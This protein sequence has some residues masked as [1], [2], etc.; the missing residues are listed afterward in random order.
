MVFVLL[1]A[2]G[3]YIVMGWSHVTPNYFE[4]PEFMTDGI[5]GVIYA[6]ITMKMAISGATYVIGYSSKAKNPVRDFPIVIIASTLA[7]AVLYTI[8]ATVAAGVLPVAEVSRKPLSVSA[9]TFMS[10]APYTFFVV[11]GAMFALLTTLNG[12]L[13]S[14]VYPMMVGA[15]DGWFP[16]KLG[17]KNEKFKTPH[18]IYLI[19]YLL[20]SIPILA[21]LDISVVANNT[22]IIITCMGILMAFSAMNLPKVMPDLWNKSKF[23]VSGPVLAGLCWLSVAAN[24][25]SLVILIFTKSLPEILMNLA[26]LGAVTFFAIIRRNKATISPSYSE[27]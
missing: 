6:G 5:F 10:G 13:G 27:A 26:I 14:K 23:H 2:L 21:G 12:G 9:A 11:G 3:L 25:I 20:I 8:L 16:A 1:F 17:E 7:V 4:G 18:W 22:V 15:Q 24:G 19:V